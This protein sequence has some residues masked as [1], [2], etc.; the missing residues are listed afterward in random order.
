MLLLFCVELGLVI[1]ELLLKLVT[2]G[3]T[4]LFSEV[5]FSL[6]LELVSLPGEF[7]LE[8]TTMVNKYYGVDELQ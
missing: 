5:I 1:M 6:L 4:P 8:I 3:E 7:I 2:C